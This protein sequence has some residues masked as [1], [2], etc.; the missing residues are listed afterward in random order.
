MLKEIKDNRAV[1][2]VFE[3]L[4]RSGKGMPKVVYLSKPMTLYKIVKKGRGAPEYSKF[5]MTESELRRLLKRG[6]LEQESGIPLAS[7][8][9]EYEIYKITTNFEEGYKKIAIFESEVA[10]TIENG[11]ETIGGAKQI[12]VPDRN[13]WTE[14]EK[15]YNF[16]VK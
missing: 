15:V 5:W 6:K 14:A 16:I 3:E 2:D 8:G 10:P 1:T 13:Q 7:V 11:Y 12:L 4:V 9:E